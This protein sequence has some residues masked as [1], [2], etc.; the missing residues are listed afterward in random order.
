[1]RT[2]LYTLT[3][4]S[5]AFFLFSFQVHEKSI[6]LPL[7]PATIL[8][9]E[10]PVWVDWFIQ[11]ALFSLY[12]LLKKD[13]SGLAFLALVLLWTSLSSFASLQT[14]SLLGRLII[15]GSYGGLVVSVVGEWFV[16]P[17]KR[18]P[19]IYVMMNVVV[20]TGVF[21]LFFVYMNVQVW[22]KPSMITKRE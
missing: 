22:R 2:F 4:V 20:S 9:L 11:T 19:D 18:L 8:F 16:E 6:L 5:L 17:P 13:E 1:M 3:N 10:Q 12:P 14:R 21:F 15:L 7:L